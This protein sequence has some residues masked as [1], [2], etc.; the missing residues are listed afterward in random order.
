VLTDHAANSKTGENMD[1]KLTWSDGLSFSGT[2]PSGFIIPI[3]TDASLGGADDGFRPMELM[4][5]SLA[6]CT[7]MDVMSILRKKQENV[8]DFE[9]FFH[10]KRQSEHPKVFTAARLTYQVT[11]HDIDEGSIRRAIELSVTKY[12]PA[13]A[14]LG[15]VFPIETVY[16]VY[17]Q[18]EREKELVLRGTYEPESA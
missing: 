3:G 17:E 16:E 18:G 10:G 8:S 13:Y 14:M 1:V 6:G 9:V 12:C 4:A 11:G 5:L 15:K 2:A 7:A